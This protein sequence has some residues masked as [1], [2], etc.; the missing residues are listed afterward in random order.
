VNQTCARWRAR[1]RGTALRAQDAAEVTEVRGGRETNCPRIAASGSLDTPYYAPGPFVAR[2]SALI[3]QND[4]VNKAYPLSPPWR[5]GEPDRPAIGPRVDEP[6]TANGDP[7]AGNSNQERLIKFPIRARAL[8]AGNGRRFAAEILNK[9]QVIS[10]VM[11]H[12]AQ[13]SSAGA[14]DR[15]ATVSMALNWCDHLVD[16][17]TDGGGHIGPQYTVLCVSLLHTHHSAG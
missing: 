9:L 6:P 10:V 2:D 15:P 14:Y 7:M 16:I 4:A 8:P 11:E 5:I 3:D 12:L 13:L 1:T 17:G